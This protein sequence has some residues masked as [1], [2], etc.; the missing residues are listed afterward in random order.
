LPAFY[1]ACCQNL[2]GDTQLVFE[3]DGRCQINPLGRAQLAPPENR[4]HPDDAAEHGDETEGHDG[5]G[6]PDH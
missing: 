2:N 1:G 5:S 6:P 4:F 3:S